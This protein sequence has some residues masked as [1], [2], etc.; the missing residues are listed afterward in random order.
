MLSI[1]EIYL[2]GNDVR[3]VTRDIEFN[4]VFFNMK[5]DREDYYLSI[6]TY[7]IYLIVLFSP[8]QNLRV[9][10]FENVV[11]KFRMLSTFRHRGV[12][13]T[14]LPPHRRDG[15]RFTYILA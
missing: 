13:T 11:A 2:D 7:F 4:L 10:S 8:N 9:R 14:G 15:I 3:R 12:V 5:A 1:V 6:S